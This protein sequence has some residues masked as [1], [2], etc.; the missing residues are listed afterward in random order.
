MSL[1]HILVFSTL[2][3][4]LGQLVPLKFRAWAIW[5]GSV[6]AIYWMQPSTPIR[7]FDFWFPTLSIALVLIVWSAT[8]PEF[9]RALLNNWQ[10]L[11]FVLGV[12]LAISATRLLG[13]ICCLTPT[14]PPHLRQVLI[15]LFI[16][17]GL[18]LLVGRLPRKQIIT[19]ILI[20]LILGFFVLLK[21]EWISQAA[22][23]GLRRLTR[24]DPGLASALDLRW[25]GF[26]YLAF[27]LLHVLFD[28][29]SGRLPPYSLSEFVS[30]AF[31]FPAY[32]AGPIDRSQRFIIQDLRNISQVDLDQI[33]NGSRRIL[34][35]VFKKFVLADTLALVALSAQNAPQVTSTFWSWVLV[36]AYG[37][38]LYLDF[39]GYTDVALGLG[40]LLGINLPENFSSPYLK[41]NLTA[42]WN[43]WHITLAQWFRAYFFNPVT[44]NLRQKYK[45]TPAWFVILF[46]QLSTMILIGLWHGITW[47]FAFWGLWHGVGLFMHNRW[48][49]YVRVHQKQP[50][51]QPKFQKLLDIGGWI[52]TFNYVTL[53][54]IWF[55]L[56]DLDLSIHMFGKLFGFSY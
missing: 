46:G 43:S 38:R 15:A 54:W 47:N 32:P 1:V 14:S 39:S 52:L 37:L 21:S 9:K 33:F 5:I 8:Q 20:L 2:A 50:G 27:R 30:Y 49:E 24:Q 48:V 56:P 6:L 13:P 25:L 42:F 36:Y 3:L 12:T 34:I 51:K 7:N 41:T 10:V 29:R 22:S 17:A 18:V 35:G 45:S 55:A 26:S 44:R 16:I 28:A 19:T 53:G 11:F 23:F 4:I 40:Q 31:F